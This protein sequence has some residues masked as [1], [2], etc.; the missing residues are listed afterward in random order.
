MDRSAEPAPLAGNWNFVISLRRSAQ[1]ES[2]AA[3]SD[4]AKAPPA[5][6]AAGAPLGDGGFQEC[7]GLDIEMDVTDLQEGGRHDGVIQRVG[8]GKY[9]RI[10]LK[11]GMFHGADGRVNPEFWNWMQGI[12]TGTRPVRR[13]DGTIQM[14]GGDG[15]TVRATWTFTRGLPAKVAGPQLN[16]KSG[17]VAVEELHIAH[18]GLKLGS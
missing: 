12:L 7:S 5:G 14:L 8:R 11:R 6:D 10:V 2:G 9:G 18:E 1:A 15:K 3:G 17:D 13:Y 16:A 4:Q